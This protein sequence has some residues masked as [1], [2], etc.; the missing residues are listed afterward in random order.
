MLTLPEEL[1]LLMFGD[2]RTKRV[3]IFSRDALAAGFVAAALMELA[4]RN[5][6][7]SDFDGVWVTDNTPRGKRA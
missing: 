4:I 2:D 3:G 5:R 7:D 1:V 6:I